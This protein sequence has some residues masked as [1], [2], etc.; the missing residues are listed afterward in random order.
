M[1]RRPQG[2]LPSLNPCSSMKTQ[3]RCHL[4]SETTWDTSSQW[5]LVTPSLCPKQCPLSVI[6]PLPPCV[7][8]TRYP[9]PPGLLLSF[10]YKQMQFSVAHRW[11]QIEHIGASE[12]QGSHG[13]LWAGGS[14][15]GSLSPYQLQLL[16]AKLHGSLALNVLALYLSKHTF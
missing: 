8:I 2:E 9:G 4:V 16:E 13:R 15:T 3:L 5:D 6:D 7:G 14:L 12:P 11:R 10:S 1:A